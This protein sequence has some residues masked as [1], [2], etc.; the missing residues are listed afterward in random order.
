[1]DIGEVCDGWGSRYDKTVTKQYT[2][3]ICQVG[4]FLNIKSLIVVGPGS[5]SSELLFM[6]QYMPSLEKLFLIEPDAEC[7]EKVKIRLGLEIPS[8]SVQYV[9]GRIEDWSGPDRKVDM[10][11]MMDSLHE[12]RSDDRLMVFKRMFD[13][14]LKPGGCLF[15]GLD[16]EASV[17]NSVLR[18]S[19]PNHQVTS[20]QQ[21]TKEVKKLPQV[22]KVIDYTTKLEMNLREIDDAFFQMFENE[23]KVLINQ[24]FDL[25]QVR[26][27][28]NSLYGGQETVTE[29]YHYVQVCTDGKDI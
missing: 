23:I 21:I 20:A 28:F 11:M 18:E 7:V 13:H 12:I 1:M 3:E 2:D 14:W 27:S 26:N 15:F 16:D 17:Y 22:L 6:K 10:V 9:N 4:A 29:W 19:F 8:V 25:A 5:A 24:N